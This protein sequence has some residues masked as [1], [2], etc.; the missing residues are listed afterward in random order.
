VLVVFSI[1][2]AGAA[3][4]DS[5][6]ANIEQQALGYISSAEFL[7][8]RMDRNCSHN[9][10]YVVYLIDNFDQEIPLTEVSHF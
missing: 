10:G 5:R 7:T 3:N 2:I 4:A 8:D 6:P 9:S 1:F